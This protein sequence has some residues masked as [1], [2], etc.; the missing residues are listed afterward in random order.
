MPRK[1]GQVAVTH[2]TDKYW[3]AGP[4]GVMLPHVCM[5]LQVSHHRKTSEQRRKG[6]RLNVCK[7]N[8]LYRYCI[9]I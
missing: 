9:F 7:V 6:S 1:R 4:A 2:R 5:A 8:I 3:N